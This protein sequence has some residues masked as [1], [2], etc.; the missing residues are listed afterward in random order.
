MN[1]S[2]SRWCNLEP[3][4]RS[5]TCLDIPCHFFFSYHRT[6]IFF[7]QLF[8]FT[9]IPFREQQ[10]IMFYI[11]KLCIGAGLKCIS[12]FSCGLFAGSTLYTNMVESPA[13]MTH[14]ASLAATIWKPSFIRAK[15]L[16]NGLVVL[17]GLCCAGTY[18][19]MRDASPNAVKWLIASS[20]VL[21]VIPVTLVFIH[22]LN[23]E[24]QDTEKCISKGDDW[25]VDNMNYWR[26]LNMIRTVISVGA[27]GY[28][29]W[30]I[31]NNASHS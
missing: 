6:C 19:C 16:Q 5:I 7:S 26:K 31:A 22:P 30:L 2:G 17:S 3:M 28:M 15:K 25:I 10:N 27:F 24:L 11:P 8:F 23:C 20:M 13:M 1:Q 18:G 21:S 14:D 9:T 4:I 29:V 12:T